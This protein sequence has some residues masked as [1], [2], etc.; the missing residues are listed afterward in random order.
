MGRSFRQFVAMR[1]RLEARVTAEFVVDGVQ[2]QDG[3]GQACAGHVQEPGEF[4]NRPLAI[5]DERPNLRPPY[6]DGR[7]DIASL[8]A[9][10]NCT[11]RSATA[12]ASFVCPNSAKTGAS[13]RFVNQAKS[14]CVVSM[15]IMPSRA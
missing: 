5:A 4:R 13:R 14:G 7:P 10:S 1:K 3:G 2:P 6:L 9:G 12:N 8:A 15:D 11:A